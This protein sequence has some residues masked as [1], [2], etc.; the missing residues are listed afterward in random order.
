MSSG[1]I[2]KD[3]PVSPVAFIDLRGIVTDVRN[4][5]LIG[6]S[7]SLEGKKSGAGTT[8]TTTNAAGE[9]ELK[10]ISSSATLLFSMT[11]YLKREVK[12]TPG[13]TYLTVVLQVDTAALADVVVTGFQRIDKKKFSG[14][15]VTLNLDDV[16][17]E[18]VTDVSRML[19]GR[20][21]GVSV[22]NVSGT[23]GTAPKVR[24]RGAA[25]INGDNKPLWVVDGVVLEDIVNISNDQLS[26]GDPNTLLGSAVAGLNANDIE[27]FD[28]L[29]DAAATALYGARAMNGVIVITTR[30]GR[31]GRTAI[32][33][34]GNY[35]TQLKPQYSSFNIMN[36]VDQMSVLAEMERKGD[37]TPDIL[38]KPDYGVYGKMYAELN[39]LDANGN[40]VLKN[41]PADKR[42]FLTRYAT[43]NTDWFDILFR[44]SFIQEHNLGVSFGT[45]KSQSYFSTSFY[46]DNGWTV[47]DRVKRYTLNFHNNYKFSDKVSAGF[48]TVGSYRSQR[49]P[50]SL[51]RNAN[52]VEGTFDRDFDIN[53]FSY[54]LNTSR[55]MTAYDQSGKEEYFQR[56]FAPFN[57]LNELRN[58]YIDL[59]VLDLRLQGELTWKITKDLRYEFNGAIRTAKTTQ[60]HQILE[61]SNMAEA[62]RSANTS[63]IRLANRFLYTDPDDP[64]AEPVVVLPYGGFYNREENTLL[65]Y[66]FRNSLNYSR[67]FGSD[68]ELNVLVG[69]Q[70]KYTDRQ[71]FNNTG[72]GYQY[73]NGGVPFVDYRIL[74]E[75][76]EKNFPYYGM[77]REYDRFAAFYATAQ[78]T[79]L[80]RY[81]LSVTGRYDG[82]NRM[83]QSTQARWLPTWTVSGAWNIDE[84]KF[85]QDIKWMDFLKIRGSYGLTANLGPADN[86]TVVLKNVITNRPYSDETESVIR[87]QD[88]QNSGLTWEKNYTGNIGV[89]GGFFNKRLTATVD[90]YQRN[91]FDLISLVKTSG[92]G[93]EVY[94][95][96]NYADM[97]GRGVEVS[98]GGVIVQ[99]KDFK[100]RTN[101]TFEYNT[102]KITNAKNAPQIFDLVKAEGGNEQGYP[103]SSLFSIQYKGLSHFQGIPQFVNQ[104]GAISPDVYL[105]DQNTSYL[106]YEGPVAPP[107]NGGLANTFSYKALSLSVFFTAQAGNKIRLY[108]AFRSSYSDLDAMPKEFNDRWV[109]P[110]DEK[111]TNIPSILDAYTQTT[112]NGAYPYNNYNYSTERVASGAFVRLKSVSLTWQLSPALLRRIGGFTNLSVT[113]AAIN[114][115][116][117]L[118]DS[119]LRGQDPEFFNAGGVAQ[120]LQ[121]QYTLSIKAAL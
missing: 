50:G 96:A 114:P 45:D 52:P 13:Q 16:K 84:E 106:K 116:L 80:K 103:V 43:A 111:Y 92:I 102:N 23:F 104:T 53:P 95:Y 29:K 67:A 81:D 61:N 38:D 31:A 88:L 34:S 87:I 39:T 112:L 48:I 8:G 7:V 115:W 98:L 30:K 1:P 89:D 94:K 6:V 100:W 64:E 40:F 74:K 91:S 22:Q 70:L 93:G 2:L 19:E 36:S 78:Y 28:I 37:L 83:G 35:S 71:N 57:I 109:M 90:V 62:Y 107:V 58:N 121:K 27:S 75:T 11:G 4:I 32:T 85:M 18:G 66:D 25:S 55:T 17:L 49:A 97:R 60:E 108:P 110:G 15:A 47:A 65:N 79:Y 5:P 72:Y 20:A 24:I 9:F 33:Y 68:H 12:L 77:D 120:P 44:N 42:Q 69:Q 46:D 76:I 59:S 41:T 10:G 63:T 54:S 14:A 56:N 113:G 117:I 101:I 118:S 26:S 119:K 3:P 99:Q 82:S 86:S 105:Q 51:A 21:A 73:Q